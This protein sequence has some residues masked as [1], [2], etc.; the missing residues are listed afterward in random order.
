VSGNGRTVRFFFGVEGDT[1]ERASAIRWASPNLVAL[2]VLIGGAFLNGSTRTV[3]WV[4]AVAITFDAR[5]SRCP[6]RE[7]EGCSP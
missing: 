1:S 2:A 5:R 7:Q 6:I 3:A 4:I